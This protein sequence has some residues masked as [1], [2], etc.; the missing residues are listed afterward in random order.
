MLRINRQICLFLVPLSSLA[1]G[2]HEYSS[3]YESGGIGKTAVAW[4]LVSMNILVIIKV[5]GSERLQSDLP[6]LF[7]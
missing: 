5:V 3:N 1:S 4:L 2:Q 6:L 7:C